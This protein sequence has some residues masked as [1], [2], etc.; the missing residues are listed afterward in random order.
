ML[1]TLGEVEK[2]ERVLTILP[3]SPAACAEWKR[4]VS[5]HGVMGSK[6]H[7]AKLVAAM[8]VHG[9][10]AI[11]TFNIDDFARYDVEALHP[12]SLVS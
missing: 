8:K 7:D 1:F 12:A 9:V 6:V 11:L 3:E 2:I 10:G 5:S 4:L